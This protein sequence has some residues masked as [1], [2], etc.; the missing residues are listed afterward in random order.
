MILSEGLVV[1]SQNVIRLISCWILVDKSNLDMTTKPRPGEESLERYSSVSRRSV[2]LN[3]EEL[4]LW[5]MYYYAGLTVDPK[6]FRAIL[7]LLH[8]DIHPKA[9][10]DMLEKVLSASKC[11]TSKG[12][13]TVT[14]NS[15]AP[16]SS[17]SAQRK[18]SRSH[19]SNMSKADGSRSNRKPHRSTSASIIEN[20][21]ST[22]K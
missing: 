17:Q 16:I 5:E 3:P 14:S 2:V 18:S 4:E 19:H 7:D 6:V 11:S 13:S 12:P 9:I 15:S 20:N 21:K 22:E 1:V 10:M 8:L